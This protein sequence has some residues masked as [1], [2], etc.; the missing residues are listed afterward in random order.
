MLLVS[1]L[2]F[3]LFTKPF[4]YASH[5]FLCLLFISVFAQPPLDAHSRSALAVS[6]ISLS[7]LLWITTKALFLLSST[8]WL[9]LSLCIISPSLRREKV[10]LHTRAHCYI[11]V[12]IHSSSL[13]PTSWQIGWI[14]LPVSSPPVFHWTIFLLPFEQWN[15]IHTT[16]VSDIFCNTLFLFLIFLSGRF[17]CWLKC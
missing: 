9:S 17:D 6:P 5:L 3:I 16:H 2:A 10:I 11:C 15:N 8:T 12:R 14:L 7:T 1:L 4:C 13:N